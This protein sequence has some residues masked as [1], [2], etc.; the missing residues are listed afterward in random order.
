[1][2]AESAAVSDPIIVDVA[3]LTERQLRSLSFQELLELW[4]DPQRELQ[5]RLDDVGG[6]ELLSCRLLHAAVAADNRDG[7]RGL[8]EM[9]P[10]LAELSNSRRELPIHV[11]CRLNRPLPA[12]LLLPAMSRE[13]VNSLDG[14]GRAP[15]HWAVELGEAD[16]L[17]ELLV[18]DL[19][20]LA[21]PDSSGRSALDCA[22][23]AGPKAR[24]CLRLLESA[25]S[26]PSALAPLRLRRLEPARSHGCRDSEPR[27]WGATCDSALLANNCFGEVEFPGLGNTAQ[28]CRVAQ[29]CSDADIS[30]L[31]LGCWA[32][33]RPS[34][35]LSVHGSDCD[36]ASFK[37]AWQ[38]G[39]WKTAAGSGAWIVTDCCSGL[40]RKTGQAARD[41]CDA[42][43]SDSVRAIGVCSWGR[44]AGRECLRSESFAGCN[45][46]H[47]KSDSPSD[48]DSDGSAN[49]LDPNHSHLL[50]VDCAHRDRGCDCCRTD[51]S[52]LFRSRFEA[53]LKDWPTL[54]AGARDSEPKTASRASVQDSTTA[55]DPA[56]TSVPLC[57][58]LVGGSCSTCLTSLN[59][60]MRVTGCPLLIIAGTGGLSDLLAQ[61][62]AELDTPVPASENANSEDLSQAHVLEV[63][64]DLSLRFR[65]QEA[66][67]LP[68]DAQLDAETA[69]LRE[70][71]VDCRQR[72][73]VF[74]LDVD[75]ASDLDGRILGC[76]LN[77]AGGPGGEAAAGG[78]FNGE[79]LRV[80]MALD[81]SDIAKEKVFGQDRCWRDGQL[82]S[83]MLAA[84][85]EN[86][87]GFVKLF[88]QQGFR[89]DRFVTVRLLETLYTED[90]CSGNESFHAFRAC[91]D[92]ATGL[93][94]TCCLN[95]SCVGQL[96]QSLA[97]KR[98]KTP[99][100]TEQPHQHEKHLSARQ[101]S[102]ETTS[103]RQ[104][105]YDGSSQSSIGF[106]G[107]TEEDADKNQTMQHP[108]RDLF[109]WSLL[110]QRKEFAEYFWTLEKES[111][112]AALLAALLLRRIPG[113]SG[114]D[115]LTE[116]QELEEMANA[117]ESRA[118]GILDICASHDE[119]LA[120]E[121]LVRE[122]PQYGDTS[123]LSLAADADSIRFVSHSC[124]Q[125]LL[126]VLWRG[127][128]SVRRNG[129]ARFLLALICGALMPLLLPLVI[130][131]QA[132]D[133]LNAQQMT[134]T[135]EFPES[136]VVRGSRAEI[137]RSSLSSAASRRRIGSPAD[138]LHRLL[139]FY[140]SPLVRFVY[141]TLAYI[142][143]LGL[144]SYTL[145]FHFRDETSF[146][147]P[148]VFA[149]LCCATIE[150]IRQALCQYESISGY[151]SSMWNVIDV[152]SIG[153][154]IIG[155]L[156]F[157]IH[158]SEP[159]VSALFSVHSEA[160]LLLLIDNMRRFC[161]ICFALV[162]AL[163]IVRT[164]RIF[165]IHISL[166]PVLL[167]VQQMI[168]KDLLPFM[169]ILSIVTFGYGVAM[170]SVL[171]PLT[172]PDPETAI[173]S[174]FKVLRISYFQVFGE[175]NLDLLTGEAVDCRAPNSTNCPDPWGAWIAPAMLGVHVMLS[176]CLLM[177][178]LIAMFSSTFQ[179]IQ[180]SSWQ[181]WSLL[182]YQI[183][184][185]FSGYSPIAPPLIIIWHLILA[186][187]QLL[188]R[189]SHAKRLGF[190]S[191]NDAFKTSYADDRQKERQ[192]MQWE[193]IRALE[194]LRNLEESP[195][196]QS[197]G[198]S[199]TAAASAEAKPM[200]LR[201]AGVNKELE[202]VRSQL[203]ESFKES[204]RE[205]D[206]RVRRLDSME[207]QLGQLK[208]LLEGLRDRLSERHIEV[209]SSIQEEFET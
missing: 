126:T 75:S 101:R 147:H 33:S 195:S 23:E 112:P 34:L 18:S 190:N 163:L 49:S 184:K 204:L 65:L 88:V 177:N 77:S 36:K 51:T 136:R 40:A 193:R 8:L 99:Y 168:V 53:L 124:C 191:V 66:W 45:P 27:A 43:G 202:A 96:L 156:V 56:M 13:A 91:L 48:G 107:V 150:D 103:S 3:E 127:E 160:A 198:V 128:L 5:L 172:D 83:F 22:R 142:I 111:M 155:A 81:R 76:L 28:F 194:F 19:C 16:C 197:A 12:A 209:I 72:M 182:R 146:L 138:Y 4:P 162:L 186:A 35:V 180:G 121:N 6:G 69:L 120:R 152:T 52:W 29:T 137:P 21:L 25:A 158:Y 78:S 1:M 115:D 39:L 110:T 61:L 207:A 175:L 14:R 189:C 181:H 55:E 145:L 119:S 67:Q 80:A 151:L 192:L 42:Y 38:K 179:L 31:L 183:M 139:A 149:W 41:F 60:S 205:V 50:L 208:D 144:Y 64:S 133:E 63:L 82:D 46:A 20:D 86:Q 117:F 123:I 153:I 54:A 9:A 166:G 164:L 178:L 24:A 167:M 118:Y 188:M 130:Y 185:D 169:L 154:F 122:L 176:S 15:L 135:K 104:L 113:L 171:F 87:V 26:A 132:D 62:L 89:L 200:V 100:P 92:A 98:Y 97:G 59:S 170:W 68:A 79:R 140:S 109:I 90:Y 131:Y 58:V 44:S 148:L 196:G 11:A 70:L 71:L 74:T 174:I 93:R 106:E 47:Y 159:T 206:G 17:A 143:F 161:R 187:R 173:K 2:A 199:G 37:A 73:E 85:R 10:G 141:T 30:Q 125:E 129:P 108:I 57:S 134:G 114:T 165:S 84:L 95:L 102:S 203:E 201:A 32:L 116:R 94:N 105:L 157:I 7:V